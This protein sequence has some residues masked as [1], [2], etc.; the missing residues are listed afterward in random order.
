M[1]KHSSYDI[2]VTD[3][4]VIQARF[5]ETDSPMDQTHDSEFDN[6]NYP[7]KD[8]HDDS[9]N[10][11]DEHGEK[12]EELEELE[13][14]VVDDEV[15]GAEDI[16][17]G[18]YQYRKHTLPKEDFTQ[19]RTVP[20]E[21]LPPR[22]RQQSALKE[23]TEKRYNTRRASRSNDT[24]QPGPPT[25]RAVL[26]NGKE[27]K[28][29]AEDEGEKEEEDEEDE[30]Q[31]DEVYEIEEFRAHKTY[32]NKVLKYEV[33]WKN[34]DDD[35]N[36]WEPARMIHQDCP[37]L[38]Q[39]YWANKP[40]KPCNLPKIKKRKRNELDESDE[41]DTSDASPIEERFGLAFEEQD[42]LPRMRKEG[43]RVARFSPFPTN[44]TDWNLE[45]RAI[46]TVQRIKRTDQLVAYV[47]WANGEK[48]VHC[49]EELHE[50]CP[51]SL[52]DYY[53]SRIR[54]TEQ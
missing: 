34:Y 54:F 5:G 51:D 25:D 6:Y 27:E 45:L 12:L 8:T 21:T 42:L 35:Y 26:P 30:E 48:T 46:H 38:V 9:D 18:N 36:T 24:P 49:V 17:G 32:R 19:M 50:K 40:N 52:I 43:Y 47:S 22:R 4:L 2:P 39:E 10:H 1:R 3:S 15:Q 11:D 14:E 29:E 41:S 37:E 33:K 13:E 23:N 44:L 20:R 16:E 28:Q 53:Q 7:N 31:E